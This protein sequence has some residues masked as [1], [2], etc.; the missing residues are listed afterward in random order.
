ML[1]ISS[2]SLGSNSFMVVL[3]AVLVHWQP[4][5]CKLSINSEFSEEEDELDDVMHCLGL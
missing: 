4:G 1:G 2:N 5:A 3:L